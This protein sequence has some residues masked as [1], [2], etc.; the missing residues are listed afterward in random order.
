MIDGADTA[1]LMMSSILVLMMTLPAL[2]FFYGGLV[3]AK[4]ILSVLFQCAAI[5]AHWNRTDRMFLAWTKPP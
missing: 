5:A 1:W 4:N 2:G 3:Q